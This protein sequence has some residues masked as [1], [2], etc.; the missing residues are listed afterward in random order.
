[1][2]KRHCFGLSIFEHQPPSSNRNGIANLIQG[3]RN[4]MQTSTT[5]IT[6]T[7]SLQPAF[8]RSRVRGKMR[9]RLTPLAFAITL[10]GLSVQAVDAVAATYYVNGSNGS[11]SN[12]GTSDGAP[13]RT[14]AKATQTLRAG[15]TVLIHAG[16]YSEKLWPQWSGNATSG[17]IT[18]AAFGDGTVTVKP[19]SIVEWTGAF[20]IPDR[21]SYAYVRDVNYIKVKGLNFTGTTRNYG[22]YGVAIYGADGNT[23][24][25]V[26]FENVK[27]YQN[28]TGGMVQGAY[29]TMTDSEVYSNS[30]SGF[31]VFS[32]ANHVR[33][34]RSKFHDNG[35]GGC[36]CDGLIF[37]DVNYALIEDSEAYGQYDG[38]D[39]GSA[40]PDTVGTKHIIFRRVI[41][42][43]NTNTN[44]PLS[45]SLAGPATYEN[46]I[47]WG[48]YSWGSM[49][50][51]DR[52]KN[53]H[54]WNSIFTNVGTGILVT[55]S[56]SGPMYYYNNI[57]NANTAIS[58]SSGATVNADYNRIQG[59]L[60]G[61]SL[62][63]HSS[64][65]SVN[66]VDATNHDYHLT[67]NNSALIDKGTFFMRTSQSGSNTSVINVNQDPEIYFWIGDSIQIQGVGQR[68]IVSMTTSSITVDA[69][70]T[71]ASNA[72]VHLPWSG[73]APDIGAYEYGNTTLAPP[74]N[75]RIIQ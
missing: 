9:N 67:A 64:T 55:D 45:T 50:N 59:A 42:H 56:S 23:G 11:D 26:V 62:G 66:F 70:L 37:Q 61:L 63:A 41:S 39:V 68:T 22:D 21:N 2:T 46:V 43:D 29:F 16:T 75:L 32:P 17:Y 25:N 60:S 12:A 57:F 4:D 20:Y 49:V 48:N 52:S 31:Q 3:K 53:V 10:L 58:N 30:N 18:Y 14:L 6:E 13:W 35:G 8:N 24:Q 40:P 36:N 28:G 71:Y 44:F 72:G 19:S 15:D 69:P 38:F 74:T 27:I 47:S 51:Y 54:V 5:P 33:I 65:G 1:M 73:A 34:S 7:H